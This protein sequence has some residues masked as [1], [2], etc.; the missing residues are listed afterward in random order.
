MAPKV[1]IYSYAKGYLALILTLRRGSDGDDFVFPPTQAQARRRPKPH[2]GWLAGEHATRPATTQAQIRPRCSLKRTWR[3]Y[4][5][6][7]H[8]SRRT[9]TDWSRGAGSL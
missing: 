7:S 4:E 2:G 3:R 6:S 9:A 1:R 8:Q 5:W